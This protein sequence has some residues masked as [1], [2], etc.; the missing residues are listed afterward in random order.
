MHI[1]LY[2]KIILAITLK[3]LHFQMKQNKV[4]KNRTKDFILNVKSFKNR[5]RIRE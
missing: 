4:F 3:Y 1:Y 2:D 5:T